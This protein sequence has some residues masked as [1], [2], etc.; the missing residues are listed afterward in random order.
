MSDIINDAQEAFKDGLKVAAESTAF[1]GA[2]ETG[3][4]PIVITTGTELLSDVKSFIE[5]S[6]K[7]FNDG[8]EIFEGAKA[9]V[10]S[11][12]FEKNQTVQTVQKVQKD[13]EDVE[14]EGAKFAKLLA[15]IKKGEYGEIPDDLATCVEDLATRV[16]KL[17]VGVSKASEVTSNFIK[18]FESSILVI[19]SVFESV[20]ELVFESVELVV[21]S[22]ELVVESV[23]DF[24]TIIGIC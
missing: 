10:I 24:N 1:I 19:E 23:E 13:L 16:E 6:V 18:I 17:K 2:I 8:K 21:E 5:D 14:K 9:K 7:I 4:I 12:E 11:P 22:V 15:D 20:E 3:N